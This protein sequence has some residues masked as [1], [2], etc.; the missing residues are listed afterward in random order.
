M[1][2]PQPQSARLRDSAASPESR[3]LV[4][5]ANASM[6]NDAC[7][8]LEELGST[9]QGAASASET[10]ERHAGR[11][12]DLILLDAAFAAED[13]FR[14][15]SRLRGV[16]TRRIPLIACAEGISERQRNAMLRADIDDICAPPL[17]KTLL[18]R[19]LH[20]W[21][22]ADAGHALH[23]DPGAGMRSVAQLLGDNYGSIVR[24]FHRDSGER[25]ETL[26]AGIRDGAAPKLAGMAH[27]LCG[28]CASL[29]AWRMAGL[30]RALELQCQAGLDGRLAQLMEAI[31]AEYRELSARL[32]R[33]L[34][35]PAQDT[36]LPEP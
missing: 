17:A 6:R 2:C 16:T 23:D 25:L 1:H 12:Y 8:A 13:G 22:P 18:A 3:I 33:M 21:L 34:D 30:C 32:N 26:R 31:D 28:S 10:L 4:A 24:M 9:A 27:A 36:S 11:A 5:L 35:A 14:L 15:V 19:L 20:L 7:L 29:G